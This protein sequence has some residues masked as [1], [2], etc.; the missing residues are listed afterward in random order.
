M[1]LDGSEYM[2]G[3][4]VVPATDMQEALRLFDMYLQ[5]QGMVLLEVWKRERYLPEDFSNPSQANQEINES[6]IEA[7][8]NN[9]IAYVLGISSEAL[10]CDKTPR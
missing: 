8:K 6:A 3:I 7:L 9:N 2:T 5:T 10:R 4:G 1:N